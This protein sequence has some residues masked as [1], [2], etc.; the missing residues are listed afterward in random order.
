MTTAT[1]FCTPP[2]LAE[3]T[4]LDVRTIREMCKKKILPSEIYN[5]RYHIL[6]DRAIRILAKRAEEFEGHYRPEPSL[7]LE[8]LRARERENK[9]AAKK[10]SAK[11]QLALDRLRGLA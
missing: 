11:Q 10:R 9:P 3:E 8:A 6:H 1:M 5:G 2:K 7:V 4:G